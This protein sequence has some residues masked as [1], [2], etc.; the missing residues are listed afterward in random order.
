VVP[1]AFSQRASKQSQ[2]RR[3]TSGRAAAFAYPRIDSGREEIVL[4][5]ESRNWDDDKSR[6]VAS[7]V[8]RELG[9]QIDAIGNTKGGRAPRTS[10]RKLMRQKAAALYLEE[11]V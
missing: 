10:N 11:L 2:K 8:T 1:R 4:L 5:V 3:S 6:H 7:A 9:H